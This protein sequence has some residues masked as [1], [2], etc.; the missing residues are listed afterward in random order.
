MNQ[1]LKIRTD[2]RPLKYGNEWEQIVQDE[3]GN[4]ITLK[5][6]ITNIELM[7]G[8]EVYTIEYKDTNSDYFEKR[9][10]KMGVGTIYFERIINNNIEKLELKEEMPD[11]NNQSDINNKV[12][13]SALDLLPQKSLNK[14]HEWLYNGIVSNSYYKLMIESILEENNEITYNMK[15]ELESQDMNSEEISLKYIANDNLILQESNGMNVVDSK[16]NKLEIIKVL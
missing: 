13:N 11:G 4:N 10:I 2:S 1:N 9:K 8:V 6:K 7:D 16:Y 3:N 14:T 15:V 5:S 12:V